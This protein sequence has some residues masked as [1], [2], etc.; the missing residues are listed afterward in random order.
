MPAAPK[1]D[2]NNE[3]FVRR[4]DFDRVFSK[5]VPKAT[6]HRWV[7]EGKIKKARDL[8][9]WYLLNATLVHQGM[10]PVDVEVFKRE[11]EDTPAGLKNS[12]L[13]Y[14]AVM[15]SDPTFAILTPPRFS[16]PR[17]LTPEEVGKIHIL[18]AEHEKLMDL[19]T[20]RTERIIYRHGFL[21]ALDAAAFLNDIK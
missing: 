15:L 10:Q 6:F 12:Q 1:Y 18:M 3:I 16:L 13:L 19:Y 20:E 7:N 14:L 11:R 5:A 2:P 8:E 4:E 9:G 17:I 21:D